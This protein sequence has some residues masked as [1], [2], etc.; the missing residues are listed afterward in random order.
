MAVFKLNIEGEFRRFRAESYDMFLEFVEQNYDKKYSFSYNDEDGDTIKFSSDTEFQTMLS[1]FENLIKVKATPITSFIW[2]E[3][4][5]AVANNPYYSNL[6]LLKAQCVNNEFG[7]SITISGR[8]NGKKAFGAM[9]KHYN[10]VDNTEIK[11]GSALQITKI[12]AVKVLTSNPRGVD[13]RNP[14]FLEQIGEYCAI[15]IA[16]EKKGT[17]IPIESFM[18]ARKTG[19]Q[20]LVAV[21]L[22]I[23]QLKTGF[24]SSYFRFVDSKGARFG[25]RLRI[26]IQI[27]DS[28]VFTMAD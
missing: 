19:R 16:D 4:K 2:K 26:K 1:S 12:F 21:K 18:N 23:S 15:P 6:E 27:V 9:D 17:V 8:R 7:N 25:E 10:F 20:L 28:E 22:D 24:Y 13:L 3:P 5:P 14:V 11:M